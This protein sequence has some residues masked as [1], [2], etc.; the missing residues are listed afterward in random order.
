MT[1]ELPVQ[2]QNNSHTRIVP[3]NTLYQECTN[4]SALL[5]KRASIALDK[6]NLFMTFIAE[7]LVIIKSISQNCSQFPQM[8]S[9]S[10]IMGSPEL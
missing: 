2:I 4:G 3:Y 7:P 10:Q 1:S 8:V 6:K 5:N 9:L